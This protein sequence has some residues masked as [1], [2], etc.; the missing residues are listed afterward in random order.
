MILLTYMTGY[1]RPTPIDF[2][3]YGG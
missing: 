2:S 3:T 1:T